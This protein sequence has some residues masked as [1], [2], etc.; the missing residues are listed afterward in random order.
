MEKTRRNNRAFLERLKAARQREANRKNNLRRG[1]RRE[2]TKTLTLL[3]V[4][5]VLSIIGGFL[6]R[7]AR[8]LM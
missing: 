7:R 8:R 3:I 1:R 6:I 2:T 4:G 5:F